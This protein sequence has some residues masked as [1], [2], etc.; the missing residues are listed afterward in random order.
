MARP[1]EALPVPVVTARAAADAGAT[2]LN[3]VSG[4]SADPE[5][6]ATAAATAW[7]RSPRAEIR[8]GSSSISRR[9]GRPPDT[10]TSETPRIFRS[11]GATSSSRC[12]A[13]ASRRKGPVNV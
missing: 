4:L 3:D 8:A 12:R 13:S 6:R 11:S 10:I 9:R 7:G 1:V 5:M 2:I